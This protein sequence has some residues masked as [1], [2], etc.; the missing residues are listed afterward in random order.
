MN[1]RS[2]KTMAVAGL[3][4]FSAGTAKV[5]AQTAQGTL[6][7]A[8]EIVVKDSSKVA[9]DSL[10]A[11]KEGVRDARTILLKKYSGHFQGSVKQG[12]IADGSL[13][14]AEKGKTI[15]AP[16]KNAN[17]INFAVDGGVTTGSE[18]CNQVGYKFHGSAQKHNTKFDVTGIYAGKEPKSD[19]IAKA[20]ATQFFPL[21]K[22]VSLLAKGEVEGAIRRV[23]GGDSFGEAWPQLL[24]GAK[25]EHKF[26]NGM[27]VAVQ[28]EAG[29]AAKITEKEHT[30][31]DIPSAKFVY[32][33]E[34]EFGVNQVSGFVGATK[35]AATGNGVY[36]GVRF[37][38]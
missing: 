21:N 7:K 34:G 16:S 15:L 24:G 9:S 10:A 20:S 1:I 31:H 3:M 14:Y 23:R 8:S 28:G 12:R 5:A 29:V 37:R 26:D 38:F 18:M 11:M 27:R 19:F 33:A 4:A 6:N 36:G 25:Y 2:L 30:F 17:K 13:E 22:D 35:D 32:N